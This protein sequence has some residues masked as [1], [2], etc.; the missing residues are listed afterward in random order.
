MG[1]QPVAVVSGASR[2][3]GAATA[4][5]FGTRGYHVIVNYLS[6]ADAA[7]TVVKEIESAGGSAQAAQADVPMGSI[8]HST[9]KAALNTFSRQVAAQAAA[10]GITVNTVAA[11]AVATDATAGVYTGGIR[12]FLTERSV[13]GRLMAP[14]DLG[15]AI[16]SLT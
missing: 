16:A 13:H 3:I 6:N 4:R 8:A 10:H 15:R 1:E 12:Q 14:E 11:G 5:E 2:G 7:A 9:A